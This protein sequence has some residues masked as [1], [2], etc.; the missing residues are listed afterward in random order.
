MCQ[1]PDRI[2]TIGTNTRIMRI[3]LA[4]LLGTL[5]YFLVGWLVFEG[6]LGR[7]MAVH[8]TRLP[9]FH[10]E[11]D[12]TSMLLLLLSCMA[13]A[14]LLALIFER[15]AHVHTFKEGLLLGALIGM[16]VAIMT[17]LYWYS[18]SHF[19]NSLWPVAA[20]VVAAA[21]T[22]GVMGGVIAWCLG[23]MADRGWFAT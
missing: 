17:D 10:K 13:Y 8:T 22:V 7:Y 9:G 12:A 3:A 18:T 23:A 6:I 5:G 11:G 16:L 1:V 2:T 20:D 15:W 4:T 14:L 21:F 19:F